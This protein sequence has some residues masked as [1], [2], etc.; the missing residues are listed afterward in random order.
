MLI[1][2]YSYATYA[3]SMQMFIQSWFLFL[4]IENTSKTKINRL[5]TCATIST[6]W[7]ATMIHLFFLRWSQLNIEHLFLK[8]VQVIIAF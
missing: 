1:H 3:M 6:K 7:L 5:S 4:K 2:Y 8:Y